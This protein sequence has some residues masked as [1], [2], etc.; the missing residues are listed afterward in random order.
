MA[1]WYYSVDGRAQGPVGDDEIG[2]A[3]K[4]GK[5]TLVDLVFR[6]GDDGWRTLGEI[7]EFKD[8][9]SKVHLPSP[10]ADGSQK[11]GAAPERPEE[12]AEPFLV[13]VV[14]GEGHF[15]F[16][17]NPELTWVLLKKVAE[18]AEERFHQSGPYSA[19]QIETMLARGECK[20]S[21][22]VWRP[23]YRRW[24]RVGN[25]PEFDR[26]RKSRN[27]DQ[28]VETVPFPHVDIE[29]PEERE[30]LL[31]QVMR[32]RTEERPSDPVEP[33]PPETDGHDFTEVTA[34]QFDPVAAAQRER[35]TPPP[36]E[37]EEAGVNRPLSIPEPPPAFTSGGAAAAAPV[38]NTFVYGGGNVDAVRAGGAADAMTHSPSVVSATP[39]LDDEVKTVV[40]SRPIPNPPPSFDPDKT[41]VQVPSS[42]GKEEVEQEREA[43][44]SGESLYVEEAPSRM[45]R[46]R[47]PLVAASAAIALIVVGSQV[48][49]LKKSELSPDSS[50]DAVEASSTEPTDGGSREGRREE[51]AKKD[52]RE[53]VDQSTRPKPAE[54]GTVSEGAREPVAAPESRVAQS[55]PPRE[56]AHAI[57][58]GV[59]PIPP[60][61]GRVT[62]LE[63]IPVRVDG[64]KAVFAVNT[65]AAVGSPIYISLLA[66]SGEVLKYPSFY[67][68]A[69][70]ARPSGEIPIFDFT[71]LRLP[72]GQYRVEVA[73]GD[74]RRNKMLFIGTRDGDFEASLEAHLKDISLQQ[75]TEKK[76]LFHSARLM[77]GLAKTLGENYF[78]S[79]KDA[80]RWRAFYLNWQKDVEKA[81]KILVD[82]VVPERRN[83]LAYPDEI[84]ALRI[85]ATKLGEQAQAL[86]D[87]ILSN[88]QMR[89]IA[90]G[91]SLEIVKEF[92]KLKT[93]AATISSRR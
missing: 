32:A 72:A 24:A 77:E 48:L 59:R 49:D 27:G 8:A 93:M 81:R 83:E 64:T 66:R 63:L 13:P 42:S 38:G 62:A 57:P 74:L 23:G 37:P 25:L 87:A 35:L 22:Y 36:I 88:T 65:D 54:K 12:G 82:R 46:L 26:R 60:G 67:T 58:A 43:S 39:N 70:I 52:V 30:E 50:V 18:Q 3:L 90:G 51:V 17:P 55:A 4:A 1:K 75:Q 28:G 20:Y 47:M 73:A 76:A 89:D 19:E 79:R 34:P 45:R 53:V 80:R 16:Q 92:S 40:F 29:T 15:K 71:N 78:T 2:D 91:G 84:I 86:N 56:E 41:M 31:G 33:P 11:D 14:T 44:T 10:T 7:P 69:S 85:A 21:D 6:E 61:S 5:L 9:F 68:T